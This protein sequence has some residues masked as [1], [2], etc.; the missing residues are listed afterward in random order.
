[1]KERI[2]RSIPF[3]LAVVV[4]LISNALLSDTKKEEEPILHECGDYRYMLKEE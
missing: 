3:I 2:E 1:M 4:L